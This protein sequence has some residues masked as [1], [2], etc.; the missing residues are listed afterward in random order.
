Y[1]GL[2]LPITIPEDAD[3]SNPNGLDRVLSMQPYRLAFWQKACDAMNYRRFFDIGDLVGL[4]VEQEEVF[5][6]KHALILHLGAEGL[7]TGLRIDHVDGLRDPKC[8]LE[9]LPPVYVIVE[10]IL[11][12]KEALSKGWRAWGTTGYDFLNI[13]NEAFI[14][15]EGYEKLK[16]IY[17]DFVHSD[18]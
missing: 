5:R 17:A 7:V 11:S 1:H 12:G 9:R 10:K 2:R 15:R 13:V 16:S 6:R 14:D 3:L 8:Y 18:V 4:R